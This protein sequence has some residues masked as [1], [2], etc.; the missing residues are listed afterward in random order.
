MLLN[1]E[2][3]LGHKMPDLCLVRSLGGVLVMDHTSAWRSMLAARAPL[4]RWWLVAAVKWAE[5]EE[6]EEALMMW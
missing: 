2:Q 1:I 5:E 4:I 3:I 6:E